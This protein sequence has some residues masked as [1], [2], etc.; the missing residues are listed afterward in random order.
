M[1]AASGTAAGHDMRPQRPLTLTALPPTHCA[2]PMQGRVQ[3]LAYSTAAAAVDASS[4]PLRPAAAQQEGQDGESPAASVPPQPRPPTPAPAPV[5]LPAELAAGVC[6]RHI[7][8]CVLPQHRAAA[9]EGLLQ[10]TKCKSKRHTHYPWLPQL[11]SCCCCTRGSR[12]Q[13]LQ[14]Q[15]AAAVMGAAAAAVLC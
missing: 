13:Q 11:T 9:L 10:G 7:S 12:Q 4:H 1:P 6:Q 5:T 8:L 2:Y 3:S 14:Q 15:A